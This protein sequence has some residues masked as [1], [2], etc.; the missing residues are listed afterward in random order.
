MPD[1]KM[2]R[3]NIRGNQMYPALCKRL[4]VDFMACGSLTVATEEGRKKLEMLLERGKK[5]GVPNLRIVEKEEL[6]KMEPNLADDIEIGLFAPTAG[7][8]S[9]FNVCIALAE[10]GVLN[11]GTLLTNFMV[12]KIEKIKSVQ[13]ETD[14]SKID[15]NIQLG[16][17]KIQAEINKAGENKNLSADKYIIKSE[18]KQVVAKYVVN[19]A[20]PNANEVN[21]LVGIKPYPI[22]FVKGEYILSDK[23]LKG[24]INRPI[25]P[26]PTE[27]SKGIIVNV[28]TYG[29]ILFGPT[30]VEC[31]KNDVSVE[32]GSIEEIKKNVSMSVKNANFKK[33]IKLF[34]GVRVKSGA[35]FVVEKD[36]KNA[37]FYY[38]LGICSPGLSASP[39]IAEYFM[40]LLEKDGVQENKIEPKKRKPYINT[41]NMDKKELNTLIKQNPAYGRIICR[42]EEISEGEIID[43]LNSPLHPYTIDAI[44]RRVRPTMG[45]CQGSFCIPKLI[46]LF[47]EHKK[48][49]EEQV[50]VDGETSELLVSNI[51]EGGRYEK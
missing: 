44:K 45:R 31:Q 24:F 34:A 35:D 5:N 49:K 37:N 47:A 46:K 27:I 39:A 33:T 26:L 8:V 22:N 18:D 41:Q 7:V 2:A 40:Q 3:F 16:D 11:G 38:A 14:K 10:E 13:S 42:C 25:F 6:F 30:A 9:P 4:N 29:N 20:G 23:S 28:T 51:K 17:N 21:A 43:A 32:L 15:K 12:D 50:T 48:I 1:S 19:C 36:N